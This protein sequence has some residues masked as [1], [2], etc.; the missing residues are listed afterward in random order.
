MWAVEVLKTKKTGTGLN[1]VQHEKIRKRA[2][3]IGYEDDKDDNWVD[4]FNEALDAQPASNDHDEDD[5][6]MEAD[7]ENE[8]DGEEEEFQVAKSKSTMRKVGNAK[9]KRVMKEETE[10]LGK[11]KKAKVA[12]CAGD[13]SIIASKKKRQ[14]KSKTTSKTTT[15][16]GG[17]NRK[18]KVS[19]TVSV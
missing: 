9:R 4:I 17:V 11:K 16:S 12:F 5:D 8:S 7:S 10:S 18:A 13:D 2:E 15:K 14:T 1:D 3:R 6:D 19:T